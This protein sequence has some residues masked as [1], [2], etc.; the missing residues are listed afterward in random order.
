MGGPAKKLAPPPLQDKDVVLVY[1]GRKTDKGVPLETTGTV[2]GAL[3]ARDL[4]WAYVQRYIQTQ[5]V[6][7]A[8]LE[9]KLYSIP[10]GIT[11]TLPAPEKLDATANP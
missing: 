10:K 6:L 2:H 8:V 5:D 7:D 1:E 9:G 11:L 3:E 4:T